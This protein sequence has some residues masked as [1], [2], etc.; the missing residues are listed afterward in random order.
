MSYHDE[1]RRRFD[2]APVDRRPP[3]NS[4][5]SW[6]L[7]LGLAGVVLVLGLVFYNFSHERTASNTSGATQTRSAPAPG[8]P[9]NPPSTQPPQSK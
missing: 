8:T 1:Q 9:A 2:E 4:G 7:P 5:M 3:P 6:G